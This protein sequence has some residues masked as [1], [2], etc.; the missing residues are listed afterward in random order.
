MIHTIVGKPPPPPHPPHIAP[1]LRLFHTP[2]SFTGPCGPPA[3]QTVAVHVHALRVASP[4]TRFPRSGSNFWLFLKITSGLGNPGLEN[5]KILYPGYGNPNLYHHH[6]PLYHHITIPP[7]STT[8]TTLHPPPPLHKPSPSFSS[9]AAAATLLAP[10]PRLDLDYALVQPTV[11]G[12]VRFGVVNLLGVVLGVYWP[13]GLI[14]PRTEPHTRY[15]RH[16]PPSYLQ[17]ACTPAP[18]FPTSAVLFLLGV[19][20]DFV[21]PRQL[22]P[23]LETKAVAGYGN[24]DDMIWVHPQRH[25]T[26][27]RRVTPSD[28]CPCLLGAD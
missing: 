18:L 13:R 14:R 6:I 26:H 2:S 4:H 15:M 22:V 11:E 7:S 27:I 20:Y 9:T 3:V 28:W 16:A 1:H 21:D 5:A 25:A 12:S 8:T 10:D 24:R 17:C 19:V 23:S